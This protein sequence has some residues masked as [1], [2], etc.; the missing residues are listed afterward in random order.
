MLKGVWNEQLCRFKGMQ[1]AVVTW[2]II[3]MTPIHLLEASGVPAFTLQQGGLD[4]Y[5][6]EAALSQ[7]AAGCSLISKSRLVLTGIQ[8]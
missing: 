1:K 6:Q 2:A 4:Y 5:T 7:R 3:L 8:L